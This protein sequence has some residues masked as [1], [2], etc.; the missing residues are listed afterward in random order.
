M[1]PYEAEGK[2][3]K[4]RVHLNVRA[5]P[6]LQGEEPPMGFGHI[7]MTDPEGDEFCLD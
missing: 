4:N 7:V 5:A 3:A 6:G 2:S 1:F